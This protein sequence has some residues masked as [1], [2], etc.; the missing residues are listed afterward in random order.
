MYGTPERCLLLP[1]A[2][3]T[4]ALLLLLAA[5]AVTAADLLLAAALQLWLS[6]WPCPRQPAL[7]CQVPWQSL[8]Q[9]GGACGSTHLKL[10]ENS[11]RCAPI[12]MC[13]YA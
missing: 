11:S 1:V 8:R 5:S 12:H 13:V 2:A 9:T 10:M 6:A 4:A 3:V 7:H